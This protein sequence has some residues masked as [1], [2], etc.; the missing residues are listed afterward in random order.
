M[1]LRTVPDPLSLRDFCWENREFEIRILRE[2]KSGA[3]MIPERTS[4][5]GDCVDQTG[6]RK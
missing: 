3:F 1:A 5:N 4:G 6:I 2:G